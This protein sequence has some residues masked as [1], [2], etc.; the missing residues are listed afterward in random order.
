[1]NVLSFQ[2]A[3]IVELFGRSGESVECPQLQKLTQEE[4]VILLLFA[5]ML[6]KFQ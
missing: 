1:M 2:V 5:D 6:I 3:E 4:V